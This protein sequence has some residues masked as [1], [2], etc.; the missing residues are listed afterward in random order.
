MHLQS[1]AQSFTIYGYVQDVDSGE[2]LIGA[3]IFDLNSQKGT[4]SN[5]FGFFSLTLPKDSVFIS[6]SYIGYQ[7]RFLPVYLDADLDVNFDLYSSIQ[8]QEVVVKSSKSVRIEEESQMSKIELPVEQIKRMPSLLGET[9]VLKTLQLLPGVQSGGEGQNGLYVRGGSPD[10]NLILLDGVPVYNVSHL[11]GFFSVFNADA[12]KKV[13]LTKGGFPARYGG[14]LSSVVDIAMKEG[15]LNDYHVEGAIGLVASRISVEGPIIKDKASFIVSGRRTYIDILAKPI[16]RGAQEESNTFDPTLFF[17]DLNAKVNYILN[18]KHRFYLSGYF[19]SDVFKFKSIEKFD[20]GDSFSLDGGTDWG[21]TTTALRWNFKLNKKLFSN[22]TLIFSKY[23]FDFLSSQT[24]II[25]GEKESFSARYFSGI[26]DVGLRYS[27]DY[28]PD[29]THYIRTGMTAT[30]HTY[31]P[32]AFQF[33]AEI[34]D[35]L[36]DTTLGSV[37]SR[38]MEYSVYVQDNI[39]LGALKFNAGLHF[40]AFDAENRFYSSLQPRLSA[41]YLLNSGLSFKASFSTMTQYINLLTNESLSLPTDLWVPSTDRV[42]PQR[43]WQAAIG[44]AKT[45]TNDWEISAEAYYKKMN[46]VISYREGSDFLGL[47]QDWQDK[48]TQGE[49]ESYG[50]ELF[51]QKKVGRFTGWAGYTLSWNN[52]TFRDIN[53]GE[54]YPFKYDRRHDISLYGNYNISE[55]VLVNAVWVYGTGNSITLP[56]FRYNSPFRNF[57][58]FFVTDEIESIGDKNAFRMPSY[59]RFDFSFEFIKKKKRFERSWVIGAYNTYNRKNPYFVYASR[60]DEGN[61]AFKQVSLFPVIPSV[62]YKFKF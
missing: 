62:S 2:R 5:D 16:I 14:R 57:G 18:D 48:V 8:L 9:D 29:P 26:N 21:N 20:D 44:T 51:I 10:Q 30:H 1:N 49:G 45:L 40:S 35:T 23:Q 15:D 59:H 47:D 34:E 38:S 58:S 52:R 32:G 50:L 12:I 31:E 4:S 27:V 39:D 6:I 11:L 60:N 42:K 7:T 37:K 36:I 22:T 33:E 13:T 19:G 46:N 28:V 55:K 3:N 54:T 25:D 43:A 24:E 61:R 56:L 17:Y 41:R 53:G